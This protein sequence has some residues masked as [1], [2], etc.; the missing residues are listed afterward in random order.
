MKKY[1]L[2]IYNLI[3][4]RRVCPK[5]LDDKIFYFAPEP[6]VCVNIKEGEVFYAFDD[7]KYPVSNV[8]SEK[9]MYLKDSIKK[10]TNNPLVYLWWKIR[11]H[12][13]N[14]QRQLKLSHL[15]NKRKQVK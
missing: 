11:Y 7:W 13:K 4:R 8:F 15:R 9:D 14:K 5:E 3:L 1:I 12:K 2:N 10:Q 6:I